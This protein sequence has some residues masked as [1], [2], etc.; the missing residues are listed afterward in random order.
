MKKCPRCN[1]ISSAAENV[2]GVCGASLSG[3][4]S[5]RLEQ[6]V[7]RESEIK[8]KEKLSVVGLALVIAALTMTGVG[9]LLLVILNALGVFLLLAGLILIMYIF[10]GAGAGIGRG[11]R[12]MQKAEARQDEK[13]R[14]RKRGEEDYVFYE[15]SIRSVQTNSAKCLTRKVVVWKLDIYRFVSVT[16]QSGSLVW[17]F[18]DIAQAVGAGSTSSWKPRR[19][20]IWT[21]SR[22]RETRD[23]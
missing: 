15:P 22:C 2:C 20:F 1:S 9:V 10:G 13:E 14:R 21:G 16:G 8:A 5:Q 6:L 23:R 19:W 12:S 18:S 17:S 11:K 7:H 4:T 3:V